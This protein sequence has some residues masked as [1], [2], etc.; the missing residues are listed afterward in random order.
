M[1]RLQPNQSLAH[2]LKKMNVEVMPRLTPH[3]I[4]CLALPLFSSAQRCREYIQKASL[5][6]FSF[7]LLLL[8][9]LLLLQVY[10][11]SLLHEP[12]A[13]MPTYTHQVMELV[14]TQ[15]QVTPGYWLLLTGFT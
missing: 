13:H 7:L 6:V 14:N 4:P 15:A 12:S 1:F 9:L 10:M 3:P 8:L 11:R 2:L 5:L